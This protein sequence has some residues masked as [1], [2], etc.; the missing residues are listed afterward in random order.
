[1]WFNRNNETGE[2][3]TVSVVYR[4][5]DIALYPTTRDQGRAGREQLDRLLDGQRDPDLT[6]TFDGVAGMTH[7]FIDEFL[8]RFLSMDELERL[9]ITVKVTSMS[10]ENLET[11]EVCLERRS[12]L[13]AYVDIQDTLTLLA[14]DQVSLDTFHAVVEMGRCKAVDVATA[15]NTSPQN[16]NNRLKRLAR[17]GA[18]R[19]TQVTG[20]SHGG[21][22]YAY[23][24]VSAVV[25]S[26]T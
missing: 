4:V 5:N 21:K 7:S 24:A 11:L 1:M 12:E 6:I 9:G 14:A 8:G 16:A 19:K 22:E 23:E 18:I 2:T 20:G 17:F 15:L 26:L 13:I 3:M 10:Q 25:P